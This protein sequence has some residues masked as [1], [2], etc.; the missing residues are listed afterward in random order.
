MITELRDPDLRQDVLRDMQDYQPTPGSE[1][2][3]EL[4]RQW[5]TVVARKEVQAAIHKVGRIESYRLEA[6]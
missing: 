5:H 6:P 1:L 2:E 3:T 4:D